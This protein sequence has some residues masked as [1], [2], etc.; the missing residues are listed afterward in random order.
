MPNPRFSVI[1]PA[2]NR[3]AYLDEAIASALIHRL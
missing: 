3:Q 1:I 2:Y